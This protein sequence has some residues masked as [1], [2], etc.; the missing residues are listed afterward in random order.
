[1]STPDNPRRKRDRAAASQR[2]ARPP[3]SQS[4]LQGAASADDE[5]SA[6]TPRPSSQ[7][8]DRPSRPPSVARMRYATPNPAADRELAPSSD[9]L[10]IRGPSQGSSQSVRRFPSPDPPNTVPQSAYQGDWSTSAEGVGWNVGDD[11]HMTNAHP[12][13]AT[14]RQSTVMRLLH[15]YPQKNRVIISIYF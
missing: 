8:Q 7:P 3:S 13:T 1:M 4:L 10:T 15:T 5:D 6:S 9:D 14:L 11:V 2:G 12:S